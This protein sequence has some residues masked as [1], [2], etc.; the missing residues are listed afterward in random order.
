MRT[1]LSEYGFLSAKLKTRLSKRLGKEFLDS[2]IRAKSLPE[3]VQLL[4]GSDYEDTLKVY[5]ETGDLAMAEAA[6]NARELQLYTELYRFLKEPVLSFIKALSLRFEIEQVKAAV[7]LWFDAAV[8]GRSIAGKSGYL[9]Q[10]VIVNAYAPDELVRAADIDGAIKAFGTTPYNAIA[11]AELPKAVSERNLFDF[12]LAL[13]RYFY[14]EALAAAAR[15]GSKD[16]VI[17]ERILHADVDA[18]NESRLLRYSGSSDKDV[19][20][21]VSAHLFIPYGKFY[22]ELS[23]AGFKKDLLRLEKNPSGEVLSRS[24]E[25]ETAGRRALSKEA[26]R[27]LGGYPFSIGIVLAYFVKRQEEIRTVMTALNA[28]YYSLPEDRVRR[29]L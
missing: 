28:K 9:F 23:R 19:Q 24:S 18:Q 5:N 3:A 2:L 7:R 13:D 29:F 8:R 17:A 14:R 15:L 12:E 27:S 22:A 4:K 21:A 25:L 1:A 20:T 11:S 26:D 16:R 10:G 6:M